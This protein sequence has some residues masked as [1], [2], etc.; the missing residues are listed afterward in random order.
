MPIIP[1]DQKNDHAGWLKLR[2]KYIG[3]SDVAALFNCGNSY[4]AT[5]N[6]LYHEKRG[7]LPPE[8]KQNLLAMLGKAMEPVVAYIVTDIHNWKLEPCAFY[9]VHP[10]H[11]VLGCTLDYY[12]VESEHGPG[13]MEVKNVQQWTPGWTQNRAP[14]H[15]EL[16][17]QHQFLVTN[18][19][20]IAEGLKPFTWGCIASMHAG[21]PEDIRIMLR[22]PD[23]K[24]HAHI[25]DRTTRF[26]ADVAAGKEPSIMG[27]EDYQHIND[28][29]KFAEE[30]ADPDPLDL[31]G[32]TLINDYIAQWLEAQQ[33][34]K[35]TEMKVTEMKTRILHRMLKEVPQGGMVWKRYSARTTAYSIR[36]QKNG[37]LKIQPV[38]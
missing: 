2:R 4:T 11:P 8:T 22:K 31:R 10:E 28:M 14:D 6:E 15:I 3:A 9:H 30:E 24:V 21:N 7:N 13:I 16:Q 20:R 37:A 32:D 26:M 38:D 1:I 35:A 27:S 17:V 19:A 23:P 12:I 34:K 33:N 25:I 29:F 36:V 5:L 18:A